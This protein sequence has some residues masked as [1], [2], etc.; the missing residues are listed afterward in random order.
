L[1]VT[2]SLETSYIKI[3]NIHIPLFVV[4]A[5]GVP[6]FMPTLKGAALKEI[7]GCTALNNTLEGGA[8]N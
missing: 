5:A 7:P 2:Y 4:T 6:T 1:G 3:K 8:L